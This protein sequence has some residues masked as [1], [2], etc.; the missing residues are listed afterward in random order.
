MGI[1]PDL[2]F[3]QEIAE[4]HGKGDRAQ[5]KR[6]SSIRD[7]IAVSRKIR[8]GFGWRKDW[9]TL[10]RKARTGVGSACPPDTPAGTVHR[11]AWAENREGNRRVR[12]KKMRRV[13]RRLV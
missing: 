4:Q 7:F 6:A 8:H 2:S 11:C 5:R 1:C 10:C 13:G 12:L 9:K 3:E